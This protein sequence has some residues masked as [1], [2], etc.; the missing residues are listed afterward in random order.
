MSRL[1]KRDEQDMPVAEHMSKNIHSVFYK[2]IENNALSKFITITF[3]KSVDLK[4][5][6]EG[7]AFA[8]QDGVINILVSSGN[9]NAR[10]FCTCPYARLVISTII[11]Q[12]FVFS[13]FSETC[14]W[15]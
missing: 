12:L 13:T 8:C 7:L 10:P 11:T 6:T 14:L 5:E 1:I 3:L 2:H 4:L 9:L 15:Y